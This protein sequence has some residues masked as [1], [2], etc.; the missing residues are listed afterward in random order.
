MMVDELAAMS[1]REVIFA[2]TPPYL[3]GA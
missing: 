1:W 2:I 3:G